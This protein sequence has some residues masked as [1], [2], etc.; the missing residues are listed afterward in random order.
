MQNGENITTANTQEG[1]HKYIYKE[2]ICQHVQGSF[3]REIMKIHCHVAKL[4]Y[5][6]I[7]LCVWISLQ[8]F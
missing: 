2:T 6:K 4:R 3:S 5:M 8:T 7:I 1:I